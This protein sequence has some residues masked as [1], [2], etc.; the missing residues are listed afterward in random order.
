MQTAYAVG[1]A[2]IL[3]FFG[4]LVCF[5]LRLMMFYSSRGE[6][7]HIEM[8]NY[9]MGGVFGQYTVS[10]PLMFFAAALISLALFAGAASRA[11]PSAQTKDDAGQGGATPGSVK[12]ESGAGS[13][14][15]NSAEQTN[16]SQPA[17]PGAPDAK[18]GR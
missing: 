17:V 18:G 6:G 14:K 16:G 3:L 11:L 13:A 12:K 2:L 8:R 1:F 15:K 5:F 9:S 10:K 4:G 7:F